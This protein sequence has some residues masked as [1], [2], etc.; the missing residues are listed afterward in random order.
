MIDKQKIKETAK[1][2]NLWKRIYNILCHRCKIRVFRCT[3]DL[4]K[5]GTQTVNDR[6]KEVMDNH[7]C[8]LCSA[9]VETIMF[10]YGDKK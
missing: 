1:H 7:L 6:I 9:N 10:N 8:K 4:K 2:L 5:V 3:T